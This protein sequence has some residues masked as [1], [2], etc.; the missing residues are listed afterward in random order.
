M[1][2]RRPAAL[3]TATV[4]CVVNS[5]G[6]LAAFGAPPIPRPIGYASLLLA[7]AG[8]FGAFGLW[9]LA[10]WGALGRAAVL[11]LTALLAA[12]GTSTGPVR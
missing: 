9:R 1:R 12:P 7:V 8:V 6:N 4:I 11:A 3:T 5:L 2:N 10:P